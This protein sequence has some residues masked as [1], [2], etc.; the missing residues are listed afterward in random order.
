MRYNPKQ[1]SSPT[2]ITAHRVVAKRMY[3]IHVQPL[4]MFIL[5]EMLVPIRPQVYEILTKTFVCYG[6]TD[7]PT[8]QPTN[9][10]TNQPTNKTNY[11]YVRSRS[12]SECYTFVCLTNEG[13]RVTLINI[14]LPTYLDTYAIPSPYNLANDTKSRYNTSY[15]VLFQKLL[16]VFLFGLTIEQPR[17]NFRHLLSPL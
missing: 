13:Q 10:P 16:F 1:E 9:G 5:A 12:T 11:D 2:D 15:K 7:H 4:S 14:I 3:C 17:E 8:N 6:P